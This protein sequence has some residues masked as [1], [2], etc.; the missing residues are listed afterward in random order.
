M[1]NSA[2]VMSLACAVVSA[3][4]TLRAEET[5][6]LYLSGRGPD[7]AVEWDFLCT[8]GRKSG[9][10]TTIPVPSNWE[11][12]GFGAYNYGH[13]RRK[14][15]EQ[16]KCRRRFK[17]PA[18][19]TGGRVRIVFEGVMTD[20]AHAQSVLGGKK[21]DNKCQG[22]PSTQTLS[23]GH[24]C[25]CWGWSVLRHCSPNTSSDAASSLFRSRYSW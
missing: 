9:R 20:A 24:C 21:G 18:S 6:L 3:A 22:W 10:W 12:H 17:V 5:K 1:S 8:G 4:G 19:W 14:S 25:Q 11:F 15:D 13:S 7:D 23:S 16:G 2:R